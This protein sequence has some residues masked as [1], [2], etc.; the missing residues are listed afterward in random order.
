MRSHLTFSA[1]MFF[2]SVCYAEET[3]LV[4]STEGQATEAVAVQENASWLGLVDDGASGSLRV[5]VRSGEGVNYHILTVLERGARVRVTGH[6]GEWLKIEL[7]EAPLPVWI[8]REFTTSVDDTHVEINADRVVLRG[9]ATTKSSSLGTVDKGTRLKVIE[10][11]PQWIRVEAPA[12][13]SGY[14]HSHF[15]KEALDA[16]TLTL[17]K[18]D[19]APETAEAPVESTA[20][21]EATDPETASS[22]DSKSIAPMSDILKIRKAY[23]EKI[24]E[25]RKSRNEEITQLQRFGQAGGYLAA[26]LIVNEENSGLKVTHRVDVG[27]RTL[28]YLRSARGAENVILID[29]DKYSGKKV[30]IRG[31][32]VNNA[33]PIRIVEVTEVCLLDAD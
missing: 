8:S 3:A 15:V 25:I 10:S 1:F 17:A 14:I 23:E 32:V 20:N 31:K 2:A 26:G 19:P 4:P 29:L 18:A 9:A 21:P 7:V 13:I 27:D 28:Y 30:G 6:S 16:G 22:E 5:N 33:G 11:H 12:G 24:A